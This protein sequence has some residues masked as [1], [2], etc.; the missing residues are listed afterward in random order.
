MSNFKNKNMIYYK[1]Y[2]YV[3]YMHSREKS[4]MGSLTFICASFYIYLF[5]KN[6]S[7]FYFCIRLTICIYIRIYIFII[8]NELILSR[9][10]GPIM[11]LTKS[12]NKIC[13]EL[14]IRSHRLPFTEKIIFTC[15]PAFHSVRS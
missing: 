15:L 2:Q 12:K 5:T 13:I 7:R 6:Y 3:L 4:V 10:L 8:C 1:I 14:K 11:I 9:D